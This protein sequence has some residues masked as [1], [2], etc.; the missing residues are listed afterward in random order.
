MRHPVLH[1]QHK[2]QYF[3]DE[4]WPEEWITEA[5]DLLHAEWTEYYK[6]APPEEPKDMPADR[7]AAS[8]SK[9]KGKAKATRECSAFSFAHYVG[10]MLY[11]DSICGARYRSQERTGVNK[12]GKHV[13]L[14]I[15]VHH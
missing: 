8:L 3:R 5:I 7:P 6:P 4:N 15:L 10:L 14:C 13:L 2:L 9:G 11:S 12:E 1:P